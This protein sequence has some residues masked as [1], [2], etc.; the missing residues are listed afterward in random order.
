M[1]AII[2]SLWLQSK[3]L[4]SGS[5]RQCEEERHSRLH[6][7]LTM[8]AGVDSVSDSRHHPASEPLHHQLHTTHN[9]LTMHDTQPYNARHT[10]SQCTHCIT[11]FT[12]PHDLTMHSL[13]HQLHATR[14]HNALIASPASHDT[15]QTYNAR[16]T[17]SQC[18]HCITSFTRPH[19]LTM[20]SLHHQLHVTN[21]LTMHSLHHELHTTHN[22]LTMHDT[23]PHNA[24]IAS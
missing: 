17:T 7:W 24:L 23:Q 19:D 12:R 13:H 9:N 16:H 18:T 3:S 5:H 1:A 11:S 22:K 8:T 20:H 6:R 4:Q 14:L 2:S 21:S 15:Q 10:T